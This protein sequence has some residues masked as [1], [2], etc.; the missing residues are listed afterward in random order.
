MAA[1]DIDACELEASKHFRNRYMREWNWDYVYLREAIK[2]AVVE[3]VGKNKYEAFFRDKEGSKK[4][5]FVFYK[6]FNTIFVISGA[7]GK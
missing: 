1:Y 7:E 4:I 2:I 6:E 5:I 3:K